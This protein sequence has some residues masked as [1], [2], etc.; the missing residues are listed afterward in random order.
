MSHIR[1]SRCWRADDSD[2]LRLR[3]ALWPDGTADEHLPEMA[4]MQADPSRHAVFLLHDAAGDPIGLAEGSLRHDYVNG[5]EASPVAFLEGL[6]VAPAQ[7][8]QGAARRLVQAVADWARA[9]GLGELLSDTPVDNH[10]SRAVH[11][12][13]GFADTEAV[14][15][16]RLPLQPPA[17]APSSA[18]AALPP[19]TTLRVL[20]APDA[21]AFQALRLR[22]LLERP[23]AFASSW[24]EEQGEAVE[25]VAARLASRG[26][27]AVLGAF[28]GDE[29]VAVAGVH[30]DGMKKLAHKACLWGVYVAPEQR[31]GG[32]AKALLQ[33]TMAHAREVLGV[34]QL[35]LGVNT[36]NPAALALYQRLGFAVYG[37]ERGFMLHDGQL[38]DEFLMARELADHLR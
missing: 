4:E 38:H 9:R 1:L 28:V 32:L 30:R 34:R 17:V 35:Y 21:A 16:F 8:R 11:H 12:A 37:R 3:C 15:Y 31:R 20:D 6:Y 7:R 23:T 36:D 18:P 5:A 33:A 14:Q 10:V 27:G 26:Q 24:D 22:G 2:W 25:A 29:L 19:G 13:L